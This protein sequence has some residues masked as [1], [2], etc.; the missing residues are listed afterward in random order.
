MRSEV[1]AR[2][3]FL[4]GNLQRRW[5]PTQRRTRCLQPRFPAE[6][7]PPRCRLPQRAKES[8]AGAGLRLRE[9]MRDPDSRAFPVSNFGPPSSS[10]SRWVP[11]SRLRCGRRW[12]AGQRC[13]REAAEGA[14]RQSSAAIL[15]VG[16]GCGG[17]RTRRGA[18][19]PGSGMEET[20]CPAPSVCRPAGA[21]ERQAAPDWL[22]FNSGD[23]VANLCVVCFFREGR[24]GT[25]FVFPA[26]MLSRVR[27]VLAA[28]HRV[29]FHWKGMGR[30]HT[31]QLSLLLINLALPFRLERVGERF[32]IFDG[33][34]RGISK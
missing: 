20:S 24:G 19:C 27:V 8:G 2:L 11:G 10:P 26:C 23:G 21:G 9:P 28:L 17:T 4:P 31:L 5:R 33:G 1:L 12:G 3:C 7:K 6:R 16:P 14:P 34:T 30:D 15:L 22:S 32:D 29:L 13:V 25:E 18:G